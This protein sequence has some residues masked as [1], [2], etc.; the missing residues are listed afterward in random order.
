LT[1]RFVTAALGRSRAGFD[2]AIEVRTVGTEAATA[3]VAPAATTETIL[4][5]ALFVTV[6]SGLIAIRRGLL[7]TA[8][9]DEGRQAGHFRRIAS[10]ILMP[11]VRLR[12]VLLM[13]RA[14][15]LRL[16]ARR[17][18]LRVARQIGL[19]LWLLRLRDKAWF[20]L[21]DE[22]LTVLVT[23]IV[24]VVGSTG[25]RARLRRWI[26]VVGI[27]LPELFLRRGDQAEVMLGVLEVILGGDRIAGALRVASKLHVFFGDVRS[28]AAYFDV[29][30]VRLV[31]PRQG[32]LAFAVVVIVVVAAATAAAAATATTHPLLTVSHDF[33]VRQLLLR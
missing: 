30:S 23:V 24:V 32:V 16:I 18:R 17:E 7:L 26:V 5:I 31:N 15:V 25:R 29:G 1:R 10:I 3:A 20:I 22:G 8:A 14:A 2:I 33:P 19:R 6:L 27:L 11:L 4:T 12:L 9:G 13:L 21:R 28:G